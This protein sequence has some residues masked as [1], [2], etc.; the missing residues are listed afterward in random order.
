[1][2]PKPF[3]ALK[4]FTV[5]CATKNP[6][7]LTADLFSAFV[8]AHCTGRGLERGCAGSSRLARPAP[9]CGNGSAQSG[10]FGLVSGFG[11]IPLAR[12]LTT[13]DQPTHHSDQFAQL[14]SSSCATAS[15]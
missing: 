12:S 11:I 3:S 7:L 13:T 9:P 10:L 8:G 2:K 6:F 1:M 15:G 14:P 5:P 4:N